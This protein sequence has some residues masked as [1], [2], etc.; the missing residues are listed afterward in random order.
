VWSG[1]ETKTKILSTIRTK[2]GDGA[3]PSVLQAAVFINTAV[4]G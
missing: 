2:H 4:N 1:I 3:L